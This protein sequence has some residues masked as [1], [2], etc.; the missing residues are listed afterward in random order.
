MRC[1][2]YSA[3]SGSASDISLLQPEKIIVPIRL[4]SRNYFYDIDGEIINIR[5]CLADGRLLSKVFRNLKKKNIIHENSPPLFSNFEF[6]TT[7]LYDGV[8]RWTSNSNGHRM[9]VLFGPIGDW[10][11]SQVTSMKELFY[12]KLKFNDNIEN[13]DVSNVIDM[14]Y[15]FGNC[16]NFNQP[17]NS[18]NVSNVQ[19]MTWMFGYCKAFNQPLNEWDVGK[20]QNKQSMFKGTSKFNQPLNFPSGEKLQDG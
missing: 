20:V 9:K 10:N 18:W 15:M 16:V 13:W 2:T 6:R 14:S 4:H 17:L 7:T 12:K 19:S 1:L 3:K 8:R 5:E 11:T